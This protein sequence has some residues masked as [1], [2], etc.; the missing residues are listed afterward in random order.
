MGDIIRHA[1][2]GG[3]VYNA[4]VV[5]SP[6]DKHIKGCKKAE[7]ISEHVKID[8]HWKLN[9]KFRN[10]LNPGLSKKYDLIILEEKTEYPEEILVEIIRNSSPNSSPSQHCHRL[11]LTINLFVYFY[12]IRTFFGI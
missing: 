4:I 6:M 7:T 10:I 11:S 1:I 2:I 9:R 8:Y 12:F 3:D 5:G